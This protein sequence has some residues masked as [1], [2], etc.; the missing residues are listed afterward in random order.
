MAGL[1]IPK[2][3]TAWYTRVGIVRYS[4]FDVFDQG[5]DAG[6]GPV[7]GLCTMERALANWYSVL[8]RVVKMV[9]SV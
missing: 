8:E 9:C 2:H 4:M 3:G 7:K 1:V 6:L 5:R